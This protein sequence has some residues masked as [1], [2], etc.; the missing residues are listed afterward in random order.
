MKLHILCDSPKT[1]SGF[2]NVGTHLAREFRTMGHEVVM[3]GFQTTFTEEYD[4]TTDCKILPVFTQYIDEISQYMMNVQLNNVNKPICIFNADDAEQNRFAKAVRGT[5][6]YVPVEGRNISDM[7]RQDLLSIITNDGKI[8]AQCNWGQNELLKAGVE[9]TVIYHGYD[10]EVFKK[11]NGKSTSA[12]MS[13]VP[14]PVEKINVIRHIEGMWQADNINIIDLQPLLSKK[15]VFGFVG[16]NHGLRKRI[17]RLLRAYSLFL[18]TNKQRKDRT[19]LILRTMPISI[20][21]V[22]LIKICADLDIN[23]NVIFLFGD[24]NRLS[25]QAMNVIYNCMDVQV[26]AS[27]SEGFCVLPESPI[28]TLDKGVQSIKNIKIGDK[29]LTHKGRFKRVSKVMKRPYSGDMIHVMPSKIRIPLILT[30][31]HRVLA[32]KT[33]SCNKAK[34]QYKC[35]PNRSCYYTKDGHEYKWCKYTTE[36]EPWRKY[37]TDWIQAKDLK[38]GDLVTYPV[39]NEP[40]NDISHIKISDY[41]DDYLNITYNKFQTSLSGVY[42]EDKI[43]MSSPY[44]KKYGQIPNTIELS[45]DVMR[46]FGYFIS[47]GTIYGDR[48]I[49]FSFN[50]DE[51]DYIKDVDS[52]MK[53]TFCLEAEHITKSN[54]RTHNLRYSNQI[55]SNMLGNLFVP[56]EYITKKGKGKKENIVRIPSEFLKLPVNKLRQLIIGI[57]RG[58][59]SKGTKGTNGYAFN[60]TSETLAHQLLYILTKFN[61]LASVRTDKR[62]SELNNNWSIKYIINISGNNV[63]IFDE[64][65]GERHK[66]RNVSYEN[67]TYIKSDKLCY[68]PIDKI[69]IFKYEGDVYNLEVEEDNS[70][71]SSI[72]I[73][74]CLPIIEGFASGVPLIGPECSSFIELI[75]DNKTYDGS[76]RGLLCGSG[77]WQMVPDSSYRYLVNEQE[78]ANCMQKM[79]LDDA[80]RIQ[81]G[82]NAAEWVKQYTWTKVAEQWSKLFKD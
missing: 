23:S 54:I 73:H 19:V 71:V 81:C 77:D 27:S 22:N 46:L 11:I 58:D 63:N 74:N 60:T 72:S 17:E 45:E 16:A 29:V 10:P 41:I 15:Y 43:S 34:R 59:G 48:Q 40:T 14:H 21:G 33:E 8:I 82:K 6:F 61:I 37:T 49:E 12:M 31:E 68:V 24:N 76:S 39:S 44:A 42:T 3:T 70:Y 25:D 26:S 4:S 55:L 28:L 62:N 47:E 32:I 65:I 64:L 52:I 50:T 51:V 75:G 38:P 67:S 56:K 35:M 20:T 79:Y 36:N 66:F 9:S 53:N 18:G 5:Y 13:A 57:W 78:L 69:N 80:L 30:P 7:M 2:S 1:K